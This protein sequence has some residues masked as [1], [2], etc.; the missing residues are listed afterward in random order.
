[1]AVLHNHLRVRVLKVR[2]ELGLEIGWSNDDETLT[3]KAQQG[4]SKVRK[5]QKQVL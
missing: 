3:V 1:M 5:A 4:S 2:Y